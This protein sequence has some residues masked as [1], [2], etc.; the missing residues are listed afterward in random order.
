MPKSL[1]F[2]ETAAD[3]KLKARRLD[4]LSDAAFGIISDSYLE[5]IKGFAKEAYRTPDLLSTQK[6]LR[7]DYRAISCAASL[8]IKSHLL[9]IDHALEKDHFAD[10]GDMVEVLPFDEAV[11]YMKKRLPMDAKKYYELDDRARYR[12]FTV[13]RLADGDLLAKSKDMI[14]DAIRS[15]DGLASFLDK[16]K[17]EVLGGAGMA[18]G[19]GWYWE[20][21]YRTNTQTA[22]NVGR[23]IGF[24]EVPPLAV[25]LL[26]V[27]DT[28]QTE[29]CRSVTDPPLRLPYNDPYWETHWP[30]FHFNCRTTVRAI[31]DESE[32]PDDFPAAP[33]AAPAKGFGKYPLGDNADKWWD[34]LPDMKRRAEGYGVLREFTEAKKALVENGGTEETARP[35]TGVESKTIEAANTYAHDVLGIPK[36][37]YAGCDITTTNEWNKS[38]ADTISEFPELKKNLNF[39]GSMQARNKLIEKAWTEYYEQ[40]L[41]ANSPGLNDREVKYHAKLKT[42]LE[43]KKTAYKIPDNAAA[44]SVAETGLLKPFSGIIQ[45]ANFGGDSNQYISAL[46]YDVG[47]KKHPV[48]CD[49]IKS[50]VDH[51]FGHQLNNLLKISENNDIRKLYSG[52][53]HDEL[54]NGLSRYSWDNPNPEP[55]NEFIAEGW[56]EYRNNPNPRPIAKKIGKTI[57][58][59]NATWIKTNS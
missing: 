45:N 46:K 18:P 54:T 13:S 28:R 15:G 38:I 39:V 23:A 55:I 47:I 17:A 8:F 6:T 43:M 2:S 37:D 4:R 52:K 10:A 59:E 19:D 34:D 50:V 5:R 21:V 26:G 32:L 44:G 42:T 31:Y 24:A 58:K 20:T 33:D 51:E 9:G 11:G 41:R 35:K 12:A 22:Y 14:A 53:T 27:N 7:P 30:P 57:E 36:A 48:G 49:T 56:A 29:F 40:D 3:E 25:E 16:T 1:F